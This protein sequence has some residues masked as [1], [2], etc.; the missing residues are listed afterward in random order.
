MLLAPL[1]GMPSFNLTDVAALRM[2]TISFFALI[3]LLSA[4]AIMK[5]WNYLRADFPKLPL[6][7]YKK[8]LALTALW[9]LLFVIVLTMISGAR[10]LMTPGAWVKRG[11]TYTLTDTEGKDTKERRRKV[12]MENLKNALWIYA[13]Q[14]NGQFPPHDL[15]PEISPEIWQCSAAGQTRFIYRAGWK[16]NEGNAIL[17]YEPYFN[18]DSRYLL[19]TDG[20]LE[21]LNNQQ[22]QDAAYPRERDTQ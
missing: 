21:L 7:S 4:F 5:L 8:S 20:S 12:D 19:R 3:F 13:Q 1:A 11:S 16:L 9:G 14:H 15:V 10:E 6:L 2:Q 18:E 17:A 22:F